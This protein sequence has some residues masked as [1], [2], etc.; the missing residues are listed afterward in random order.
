MV[1]VTL[2]SLNCN[3]VLLCSSS[4]RL[5]S[6]WAVSGRSDR[7]L[8]DSVRVAFVAWWDQVWP[9]AVPAVAVAVN[10]AW[11]ALLGYGLVRLL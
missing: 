3:R 1:A 6:G 7:C 4:H 10:V 2:P 8:R 9:P 11:I 5:P